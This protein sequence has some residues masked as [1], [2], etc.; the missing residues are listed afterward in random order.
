MR[1]DIGGAPPHWDVWVG[2]KW[3]IYEALQGNPKGTLHVR[4]LALPEQEPENPG[5]H[6]ARDKGN[7]AGPA[8]RSPP[9]KTLPETLGTAMTKALTLPAAKAPKRECQELIKLEMLCGKLQQYSGQAEA[10]G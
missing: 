5:V 4:D 1:V 9:T 6:C 7:L 10:K 8:N 3:F 2:I